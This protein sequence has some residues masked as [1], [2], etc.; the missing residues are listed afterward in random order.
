VQ[1][2]VL[3]QKEIRVK[4]TRNVLK[5]LVGGPLIKGLCNGPLRRDTVCAV[6]GELHAAVD[7]A[8][9]DDDDPDVWGNCA[10]GVELAD[11]VRPSPDRGVAGVGYEDAVP[12]LPLHQTAAV[13]DDEEQFSRVVKELADFFSGSYNLPMLNKSEESKKRLCHIQVEIRNR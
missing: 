11:G 13:D 8:P 2:K 7:D 5:L 6:G 12:L 9:P 10:E 1:R 4:T 3:L